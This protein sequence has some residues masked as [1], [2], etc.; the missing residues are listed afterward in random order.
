MMR[1]ARESLFWTNTHIRKPLWTLRNSA[2]TSWAS[3]GK[4][5]EPVQQR[6]IRRRPQMGENNGG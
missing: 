4:G 6:K 3:E 5:R 2:N 1:C